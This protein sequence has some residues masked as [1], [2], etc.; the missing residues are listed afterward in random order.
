MLF[1]C[2]GGCVDVMKICEGTMLL[3]LL[4]CQTMVLV[5]L[6]AIRWCML[7]ILVFFSI[8]ICHGSVMTLSCLLQFAK[9][10]QGKYA[11]DLVH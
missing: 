6:Y 3:L 10:S 1:W 5:L 9:R 11:I 8:Q 4:L 7:V 2:V